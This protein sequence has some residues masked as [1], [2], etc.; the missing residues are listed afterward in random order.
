MHN[1]LGNEMKEA[2]KDL[3]DIEISA[4]DVELSV[5][6]LEQADNFHWGCRSANG[7]E[8]HQIAK[9]LIKKLK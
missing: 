3:V 2:W 7:G 4:E 5:K 9:K 8:T 1:L 6:W